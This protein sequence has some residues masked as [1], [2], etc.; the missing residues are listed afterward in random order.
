MMSRLGMVRQHSFKALP[1]FIG[2]C[3][4]WARARE[5]FTVASQEP[6]STRDILITMAP[7]DDAIADLQSQDEGANFALTEIAN[8]H[9]VER[10]T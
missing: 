5:N 1:C 6:T 4:E 8:R 9:N 7:I 2:S 3:T 10:S